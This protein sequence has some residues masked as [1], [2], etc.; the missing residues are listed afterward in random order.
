VLVLADVSLAPGIHAADE[1]YHRQGRVQACAVAHGYRLVAHED[2]T[3][4]VLPTLPRLACELERQRA[5][6]L[7]A[8]ARKGGARARPVEDELTEVLG[9]MRGLQAALEQGYLHYEVTALQRS[10]DDEVDSCA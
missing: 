3:P 9:H 7:S 5:R 10:T 4:D 1:P 2:L 8:F 6:L